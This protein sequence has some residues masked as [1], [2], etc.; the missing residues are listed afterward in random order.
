MP[1]SPFSD[2]RGVALSAINLVKRYPGSPTAAVDGVTLAISEGTVTALVGPNGA[3]KSTLIRLWLGFERPSGG[4][5]TVMGIDPSRR[6]V[7]ALN[8]VGYVPQG[9]SLYRDLSADDHIR[10]AASYRASF[11]ADAARTQLSRTRIPLR[12]PI[13]QLSGGQQAQ[14]ALTIAIATTAPVLI[15][16]EPLASLDPLAR[17]QFMQSLQEMVV[18]EGRTALLS[19]HVVADVEAVATRIVVLVEGRVRLDIDVEEA[20]NSHSIRA[21]PSTDIVGIVP[22]V[23]GR[24]AAIVRASPRSADERPTLEEVVIAHLADPLSN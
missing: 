18:G 13:R 7:Q 8:R 11:D 20:L 4:L 16:D 2:E 15:L 5:L 24:D 23:G 9:G 10:L 14:V 19:S 22:R 12:Q 1:R 6:P 21:N 3:G 17:R